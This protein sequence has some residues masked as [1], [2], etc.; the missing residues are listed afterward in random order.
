MV[1]PANGA[2]PKVIPLSKI[3]IVCR[4]EAVAFR[5]APGAP[6]RLSTSLLTSSSPHKISCRFE[7]L[8]RSLAVC[9]AFG[10]PEKA[11]V[12]KLRQSIF[13]IGNGSFRSEA[14]RM[15]GVTRRASPSK[16]CCAVEGTAPV[17]ESDMD[18][19]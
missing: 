9:A 15:T 12:K 6:A 5:V 18:L 17:E 16:V 1:E 3:P 13:R 14:S 2:R 4:M 10:L 19:W 7:C 11:T 8:G